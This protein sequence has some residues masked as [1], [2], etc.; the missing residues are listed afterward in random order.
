MGRD[1]LDHRLPMPGSVALI[2]CIRTVSNACEAQG[3]FV[4]VPAIASSTRSEQRQARKGF[5]NE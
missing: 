5:G 2:D 3:L 1:L 4:H